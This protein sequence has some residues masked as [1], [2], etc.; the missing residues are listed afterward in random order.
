[1]Q[2][3][4]ASERI[5]WIV[6]CGTLLLLVLAV[7]MIR[8]CMHYPRQAQLRFAARVVLAEG[9]VVNAGTPCLLSARAYGNGQTTFVEG[10]ELRCG[11][12]LWQLAE[13]YGSCPVEEH[14]EIGGAS[15]RYR[16]VCRAAEQLP[17]RHLPQ[18]HP[19]F[20]LNTPAGTLSVQATSPSPSVVRLSIESLSEPVTTPALLD[21]S[22][23]F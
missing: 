18:H 8:D 4:R 6:I 1:M 3:E 19:G 5:R 20:D 23:R 13:T 10:M 2:D 21:S 7:L 17:K 12:L 14:S 15:R 11:G 22:R 9:V 16:I